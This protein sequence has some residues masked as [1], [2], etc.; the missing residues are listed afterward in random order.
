M[1][2]SVTV[3]NPRGESI[4][5]ELRFPERSGFLIQ[6]ITGL[7]P[8]KA[9]INSTDL[10]T[11]DG[12]IYN[13]SRLS[14][15]NITLNLKLMANPTVETMR[16]LS[17]KYFPIKKRVT[18]RIELDNRTVE[19]YG[20]V[21][22]NEPVMFSSQQNTQISIVCPDPYFYSLEEDKTVTIFSGIV[23][24]FE[25]PFSNESGTESLIEMGTIILTQEQ[26]I[27]YDGDSEIGVTIFIHAVGDVT[28]LVIYNPLTGESMKI[29]TDR[30]TTLTGYAIINGDD[31]IISTIKGQKSI[32]L[33]RDGISINILNCLDRDV[34]WL[35]LS[36]G[37]NG[38][39]FYSDTGLT[40]LQFRIEN[41]TVYEGV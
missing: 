41:Q 28:N 33:I 16:Q 30:L 36:R 20:Y 25:F 14:S 31:I 8:S 15:R 9:N 32:T 17:Y 24:A 40:N 11:M 4:Q 19:T 26:N 23:P 22:S 1:I 7:G 10:S 34:D 38:F 3:I 39:S 6:D 12:S 29:D 18:L 35:Q 27:P 13:S 21:E 37:D 5:L 2:R